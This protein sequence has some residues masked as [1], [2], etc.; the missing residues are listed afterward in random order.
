ML[1]ICLTYSIIHFLL[2]SCSSFL[3]NIFPFSIGHQYYIRILVFILSI[4]LF[5]LFFYSNP[6]KLDQNAMRLC[7]CREFILIL[8]SIFFFHFCYF[9]FGKSWFL[10]TVKLNFLAIQFQLYRCHLNNHFSIFTVRNYWWTN[11]LSNPVNDWIVNNN[12]SKIK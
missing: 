4:L 2:C 12:A 6:R 1:S 9:H 10:H 5:L 11:A 8:L 3:P 7:F